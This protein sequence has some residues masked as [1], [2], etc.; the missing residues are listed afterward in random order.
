MKSNLTK[1]D[2]NSG[3]ISVILPMYNAETFIERCIR[4][5]LSGIYQDFEILCIDDG[6]TDGTL[7]LIRRLQD[8]DKRIVILEQD[9]AGVSAA[10]NH[11]LREAK[12]NY[13]A[14]IDSDDWVSP[15]YLSLMVEIAGEKNADIVS[16]GFFGVNAVT[17]KQFEDN[18]EY[19]LQRVSEKRKNKDLVTHVWGAVYRREI[20]PQFNEEVLVGEDLL[21]NIRMLS[22]HPNISAWKCTKRMYFH[23]WRPNS[24]VSMTG[25]ER[26]G[27]VCRDILKEMNSIPTKRYALINAAREALGFKYCIESSRAADQF[28]HQA[29][30]L[31][32]EVRGLL[33]K[34][35]DVPISEKALYITFLS[36][37]GFYSWYRH[38]SR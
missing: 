11:G 22:E 5:V 2:L 38:H 21:F 10:R 8:E 16:C 29:D 32:K 14:F 33:L 6:S 30:E 35:K 24:L 23:L 18:A 15:D 28:R 27:C 9:H 19:Q 25:I 13:I 1:K 36:L 31:L 37:P 26:H 20:C 34:S 4:S 3:R 12:G 7:D 17:K